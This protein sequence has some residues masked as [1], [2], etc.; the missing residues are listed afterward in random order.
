MPD[1]DPIDDVEIEIALALEEEE[2]SASTQTAPA[3][4]TPEEPIE[5]KEEN[6]PAVDSKAVEPE[7]AEE[8]QSLEDDIAASLAEAIGELTDSEPTSKEG[9]DEQEQPEQSPEEAQAED[10]DPEPAAVLELPEIDI[11]DASELD[12]RKVGFF[13][14]LF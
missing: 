9:S 10:E 13:P 12:F 6:D 14:R 3:K 8:T 4:A 1:S 11:S 7:S 5:S 2:K